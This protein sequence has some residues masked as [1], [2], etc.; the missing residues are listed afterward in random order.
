MVP[1]H[2]T[3][4]SPRKT[5]QVQKSC[6]EY[7]QEINLFVNS[8]WQVAYTAFWNTEQLALPEIEIAKEFIS[9]LLH[10]GDSH[11]DQYREFVQ[12]VLLARMSIR[13]HPGRYI[14]PPSQW[15]SE[16]HSKGFTG[17]A[18]RYQALQQARAVNPLYRQAL[19][20]FP[21]AIIQT[22]RSGEAADFHYWRSYFIEYHAQGLVNL[23]LSSLANYYNSN[24]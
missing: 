6:A 16:Q 4:P 13:S 12:R 3:T 18:K 17:T 7:L 1:A 21:E 14:P 20:S 5:L 24:N 8:A 15:F 19:K 23:Y 22:I 2:K 10:Q 11:I 9:N